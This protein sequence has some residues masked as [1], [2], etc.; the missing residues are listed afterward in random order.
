MGWLL[1]GASAPVDGGSG[2]NVGWVPPQVERAGQ[3]TAPGGAVDAL[4]K[5]PLEGI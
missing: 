1:E 2:V 3:V 4:G 5:F